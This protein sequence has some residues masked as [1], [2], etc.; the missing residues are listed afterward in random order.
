VTVARTEASAR[1]SKMEDA[2]GRLLRIG[3]TT[4]SVCLAIGLALLLTA[5]SSRA[6]NLLLNIG[7]VILMATPVGRVVISV[8]E[9][10]LERDWFFVAMTSIVLLELLASVVAATR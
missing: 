2:I 9:Y 6:A 8:G 7:L 5:G 10:A 4:S 1:D 3:V